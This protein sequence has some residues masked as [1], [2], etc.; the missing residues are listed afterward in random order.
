MVSI[1]NN[2]TLIKDSHR[3]SRRLNRKP[4]R[5]PHARPRRWRV[6]FVRR[7]NTKTMVKQNL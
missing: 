3:S 7:K 4:T 6:V 1:N 2:L 5:K